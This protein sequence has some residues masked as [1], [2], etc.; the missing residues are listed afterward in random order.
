MFA[1]YLNKALARSNYTKQQEEYRLQ[2]LRAA[3]NELI[4][5]EKRWEDQRI[6]LERKIAA[7]STPNLALPRALEP[8][9]RLIACAAYLHWCASGA[10][11][12]SFYDAA[13]SGFMVTGSALASALSDAL[14]YGW[15][16]QQKNGT[17]YW[18]DAGLTPDCPLET[19]A[20]MHPKFKK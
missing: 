11:A 20:K 5:A 16:G 8:S 7:E 13:V 4:L 12:P 10:S 1:K 18:R 15:I 14:E 17:L 3:Q 6:R 9:E 2:R 19:L